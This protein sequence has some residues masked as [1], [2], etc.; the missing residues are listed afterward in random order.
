M[1]GVLAFA[2][3]AALDNDG[4]KASYF[5]DLATL[6]DRNFWFRAR[7]QLIL[8]ALR[9][10]VP[11]LARF[12]ELGCGTGY[13]LNAIRSAYPDAE[14]TGTEIFSAG[15]A[16]AAS[17]VPSAYFYQMD[18]RSIPFR[19]HFDA[20]GAFDVLEHIED[21]VDVMAEVGTALGPEGRFILTVPQHPA[22]WS[23]QDDHAYHVRRYTAAGLRS[24][25]EHAGF[26]VIRMT[27]FVSLLL[28]LQFISR[29]RIRRRRLDPSFDVMD[30]LRIHPVTDAMLGSVMRL[31]RSLIELG[32]SFPAGGSLLVVAR[33]RPRSEAGT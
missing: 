23:P 10:E 11:D 31:E 3:S 21:D 32:I 18:A 6:E 12:L 33:T 24:R 28:P 13:V 25:L 26:E 9:T 7:N 8:W 20:I 14:L 19:D 4:F 16:F 30:E 2:P 15:L 29:S 17:R 1:N 27:S 22:L 5:A